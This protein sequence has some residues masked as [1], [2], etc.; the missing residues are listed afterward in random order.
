[1]TEAGARL[2]RAER[3]R[4]TEARI[5][6]EAARLFAASGYADTT[7]RA[8]AAAAGVNPGLVMHYFGSK[9]ELFLRVARARPSGPLAGGPDEVV[10]EMLDRLAASMADEPVESLAVLRSMLTH[11]G[12]A[13]AAA[14]GAARYRA[15]LAEA[16]PAADAGVRA[17]VI[18][19]VLIGVVLG[20]HLL[21]LEEL[22]DAP[23]EQIAALLR[24]CLRSLTGADG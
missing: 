13:E 9:E 3:R 15:Q 21:K 5:L 17:S 1:M 8:V 6:E 2:T 7:I 11:P 22:R 12:A 16:I 23:P 20:R 18:S 14:E 4:R 10:E 24:P 19:A